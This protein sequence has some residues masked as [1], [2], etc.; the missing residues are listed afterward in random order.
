MY[1]GVTVIF[2]LLNCDGDNIFNN[3]FMMV[4]TVS[5]CQRWQVDGILFLNAPQA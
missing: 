1:F 5:I 2:V 3:I 4:E